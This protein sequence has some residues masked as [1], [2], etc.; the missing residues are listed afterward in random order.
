V[1]EYKVIEERFK[2]DF[3][4]AVN[5]FLRDGWKLVGVAMND[6]YYIQTMTRAANWDYRGECS[7]HLAL[8]PK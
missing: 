2:P 3:E 7:A 8:R 1:T 4:L 5:L 6:G